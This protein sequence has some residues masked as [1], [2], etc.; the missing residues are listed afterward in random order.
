MDQVSVWHWL[1]ILVVVAAPLLLLVRHRRQRATAA[2]ANVPPEGIGG[3]LKLFAFMLCLGFMLSIAELA[4]G[5]PDYLAG[6]R[7]EQAHGPLVAIG[8][9]ALAARAV[10]LWAIVALFQKKRVL[11]KVYATMWILTFLTPFMLLSMLTVPGV[12]LYMV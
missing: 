1:V 6:F 10:H 11:R 5:M 7:N 3:W 8:L 9:M 4:K 12:R 2:V